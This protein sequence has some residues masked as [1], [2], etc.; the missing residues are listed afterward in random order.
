MEGLSE[1]LEDYLETILILQNKN[2]VARVKHIAKKLGV[3][4]GTVTSALRSLSDKNLINYKPYS[5]ITLTEKGEKIAQEVLRRHNVI[6][7]FLQCVLLL[8][9]G[10]AEENAC[11]MEHSMDKVAINRL[12]QFIEYIYEC[13]RTG[14]DWISNFN[15]F[16]TQNKIAEAN[17][18]ECLN[19]CLKRYQNTLK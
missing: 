2:T 19:D 4:S 8:D 5:F 12:V 15:T 7:D 16:F 10:K 17:C 9:D 3:L 14:E 18:P 13:P 6:K 1:N 11:R